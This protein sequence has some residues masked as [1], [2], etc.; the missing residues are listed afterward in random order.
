MAVILTKAKHPVKYSSPIPKL[1]CHP[2][3]RLLSKPAERQGGKSYGATLL[4][5]G[6]SRQAFKYSLQA[7]AAGLQ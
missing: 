2:V 7:L 4:Q 6:L 5:L 3:L 1:F